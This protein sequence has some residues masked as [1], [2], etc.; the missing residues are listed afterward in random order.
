VLRTAA[1]GHSLMFFP[2]GTF[3]PEVGLGKFTPAPSPSRRAPPVR[4]CPP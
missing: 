3:K 2:E 1:S 4:W